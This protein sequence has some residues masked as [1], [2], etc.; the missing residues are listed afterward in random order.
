[1]PPISKTVEFQRDHAFDRIGKRGKIDRAVGRKRR[2]GNVEEALQAACADRS[3]CGVSE[4]LVWHVSRKVAVEKAAVEARKLCLVS[5]RKLNT[6]FVKRRQVGCDTD[7]RLKLWD[8]GEDHAENICDYSF[9]LAA[10]IA[11]FGVAVGRNNYQHH[12]RR[13]A[14]PLSWRRSSSQLIRGSSKRTISK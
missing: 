2:D 4:L 10:L 7:S 8:A 11:S 5:D 6:I 9:A 12:S 14:D 13:P 3:S 1:M